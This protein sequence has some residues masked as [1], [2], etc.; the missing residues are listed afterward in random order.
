M[1]GQTED[2]QEAAALLEAPGRAAEEVRPGPREV[3][4]R[5]AAERGQP[6]AQSSAW[7]QVRRG[8]CCGEVCWRGSSL[9]EVLCESPL[10]CRDRHPEEI[11]QSVGR[12]RGCTRAPCPRRCAPALA[13]AR[14]FWRVLLGLVRC[15][16]FGAGLSLRGERVNP[17]ERGGAEEEGRKLPSF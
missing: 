7:R 16:G 4:G 17:L 11:G 14:V 2:A 3:T 6:P 15:G 8:W 10:S 13:R 1:A 12:L 5:R 9:P